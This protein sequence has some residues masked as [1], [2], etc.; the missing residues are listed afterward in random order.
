[1]HEAAVGRGEEGICNADRVPERGMRT[2][3][4]RK[5]EVDVSPFPV[6]PL[7]DAGSCRGFGRTKLRNCG[8]AEVAAGQA[9]CFIL[10]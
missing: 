10:G 2:V 5:P 3:P 9:L 8:E 6:R 1:M 4:G 7:T